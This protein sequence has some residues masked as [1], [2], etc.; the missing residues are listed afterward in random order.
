VG[1]RIID[2]ASGRDE[3]GDLLLDEGV[4]VEATNER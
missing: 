4:L 3:V 1:G 2:P